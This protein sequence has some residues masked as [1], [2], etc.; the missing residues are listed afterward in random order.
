[1]IKHR[2]DL[3]KKATHMSCLFYIFL[4]NA[5]TNT[6]GST[7]ILWSTAYCIKCP[8]SFFSSFFSSV[9]NCVRYP[10]LDQGKISHAPENILRI[11]NRVY[12]LI[13]A[14]DLWKVF[15]FSKS[16]LSIFSI[17]MTKQIQKSY[18][19]KNFSCQSKRLTQYRHNF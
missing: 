1:M 5:T 13:T 16:K 12:L 10:S 2:N 19:L 11:A 6:P 18:F 3:T 17:G 15:N 4:K 14:T 9:I 7:C 8:P